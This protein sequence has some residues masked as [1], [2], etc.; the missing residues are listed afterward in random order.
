MGNEQ[1]WDVVK[2]TTVCK[3]GEADCDK[4]GTSSR[5]DRKHKTMNGKGIV[6]RIKK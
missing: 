4:C 1:S 3:H 6:G 5:R 2:P